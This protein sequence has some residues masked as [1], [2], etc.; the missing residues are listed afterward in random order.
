MYMTSVIEAIGLAVYF[1]V[2]LTD[3]E[4][5][6]MQPQICRY[7]DTQEAPATSAVQPDCSQS[8]QFA[9]SPQH[10][11]IK[12]DYAERNTGQLPGAG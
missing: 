3:S 10:A 12:R 8:R 11:S 2:T 4:M 1:S 6:S 9:R 5:A 7:A